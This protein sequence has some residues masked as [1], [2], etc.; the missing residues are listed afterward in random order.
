L[1][2]ILFLVIMLRMNNS[3]REIRF[4]LKI[5]D[6]VMRAGDI[7]RER[8]KLSSREV[9]R[10]KLFEDGV[11][12]E[13]KAV[14]IIDEIKPG[15]ELVV[16]IYED[17]DNASEIVPSDD[18]I[19]IVYEDEDIVVVNKQGNVV[20]HPSYCHFTDSL[21]NALMGYYNRT[22]QNHVIRVI[23]RLDRETSGL[24]IFAKNRY[25]AALLSE[26]CLDMSRRK[27]YLALCDGFFSEKQGTIDAPIWE[28]P[29]E[30][31]V[32]EV[33]DDGK[34]AV[35]HYKVEKQ[36]DDF[37]LVRLKLDTGRTHQIRVH[38]SY[39]GHPLLGD[40]LYGKEIANN[41]GMERA[42]LHACELLFLQPISGQELRFLAP[43][44]DDMK[45]VIKNE[46][47]F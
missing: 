43:I 42:A 38:M 11:M 17:T 18:P 21:S 32:R 30:K 25:S 15:Q 3:Y 6:G 45:M 47:L 13:G 4:K 31:M 44:P 1:P 33:R 28:N 23:G 40:S 26:Q 9:T 19:D 46:E 10:C 39:L 8:L 27:E 29:K 20:V 24:I 2:V 12:C 34:R 37:A 22:G 41:H 5:E 7:M 36:F 14:R 16:R 35:T